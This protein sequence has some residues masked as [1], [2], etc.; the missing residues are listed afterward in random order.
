[1]RTNGLLPS[2]ITIL[3]ITRAKYFEWLIIIQ[4]CILIG[5]LTGEV[6][7]NK[8]LPISNF[9]SVLAQ[10][11]SVDQNFSVMANPLKL[12]ATGTIARLTFLFL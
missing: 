9:Y 8:E 10:Q 11:K 6:L 2:A 12:P 4:G 7:F 1:M 5:W 3:T